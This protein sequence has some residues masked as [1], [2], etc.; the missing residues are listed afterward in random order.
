MSTTIESLELEIQSNSKSAVSGIDALTQSLTKLKS[1]TKGGLGLSAV[2]KGLRDINSVDTGGSKA[3]IKSIVDALSPLSKLSKS[4]LSS[5][6]TPLKKLPTVFNDLNKIDMAAFSAK[7]QEVATAMKPLADEMQKVA[8]GFAA[9]PNKIQKFLNSTD[10]VPSKNKKMSASFTDIYYKM[11]M[12]GNTIANVGKKIWSAVEKSMDYTENMNLFSVSMGEYS[13]EAMKYAETVSGAMGIDTSEWI[14]AQGIFMTMATGFGVASDRANTMSQNLTQLGYDLASFYNMDTETAMLKLKSGLAGE[15]EPL[16]AIGYDLSQAKLEATALE[17]GITKSVSAMT[18]AEKAQLRYYAIMTQVTVAQG[19]MARTLEDP[20][21]Q[22]RVFKAE[23]NMAAREIGDVLLPALNAILPYAIAVTKV[24]GMLASSIAGLFGAKPKEANDSTEKVV[25]N[26]DEVRENLKEA[27][28][29]A[30]KL[31]SNLL[32]IDELNVINPN[33]DDP[34]GDSSGWVDFELPEYDFMAALAESKVA[35]I[36]EEMKEWLGLTEDIDSWADLLNTKLGDM[37]IVVGLIGL[38][39]AAWKISVGVSNIVTWLS[40]PGNLAILATVAG[41]ALAIAG[42]L[43][44]IKGVLDIIMNGLDWE[45]FGITLLGI[46]L[47]V[48]GLALAFGQVGLIIGLIVGGLALLVVGIRDF[49]QNGATAQNITAVAVAIGLIAVGLFIAFGWVGLIIAAVVAVVAAFVMFTGEIVGAIW[50]LG[51][52]FKNVGL[53]CANLGLAIW[54]VIKNVGLWFANLGTSVWAIIKNTG[55]WFANLGIG[56]WEVMKA[57]VGNI[58]AVFKNLWISVQIGFWTMIDAFL[59][60]IKTLADKA[61]PIL[62]FLGIKLDTTELNFAQNKI[63]SLKNSKEELTSVKDAFNK[64]FNTYQYDSVKE[65]YNTFDYGSI[66]DAF[67]T[68][69]DFA[70][71]WGTDAYKAGEKIGDGI[72]DVIKGWMGVS[73][74]APSQGQSLI[75]PE[76]GAALISNIGNKTAVG[77]GDDEQFASSIASG[78]AEASEEQNSLLRE[79]NSLLTEIL[80]K[81]TGVYLDGKALTNSVEK[82]QREIGRVLVTGGVV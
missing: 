20:A 8:N 67:N 19:D 37:L 60:G 25:E 10:K 54:E 80:G 64:G 29:E 66:S 12:I 77:E 18:Q 14:R 40:T 81:D 35:T 82:H 17:L 16:R 51:S 71:G 61:G 59:Q 43:F 57:A 34:L 3:K 1:A 30:K 28:E 42:A 15:L 65:A 52:L 69:D 62:D 31:K 2:A 70:E 73:E 72:Q 33:T 36:V 55:L 74:E 75:S 32:G 24:I 21:N 56:L 4:N 41:I 44:I 23:I 7:I 11:R 63:K 38:A 76:A 78:V 48:G 53:W 45:N 9:F 5:F 79:Q 13:G 58:G 27:Q 50:W 26:T 49:L 22:M 68:F 46:A 39:L 47:L 6:V